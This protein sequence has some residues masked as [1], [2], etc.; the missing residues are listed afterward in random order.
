MSN[1][2]ESEFWQVFLIYCLDQMADGSYVALNR[3]YKPVGVTSVD[4][5]EY[6]NHPVRFNFKRALTPQQIASLSCH[7]DTSPKRI[8]LYAGALNPM[9][10]AEHWKVYVH[11]LERLARYRILHGGED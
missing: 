8:Q 1:P 4:R 5:V 7:G 9:D 6:E 2:R 11:R 10:S 3:R